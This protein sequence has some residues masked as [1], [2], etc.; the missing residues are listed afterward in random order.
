MIL[1]SLREVFVQRDSRRVLLQQL[2]TLALLRR[3]LSPD[4]VTESVAAA[5][6]LL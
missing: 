2:R 5:R 3:A 6:G 1:C 4:T